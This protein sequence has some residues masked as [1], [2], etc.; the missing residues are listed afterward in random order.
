MTEARQA[1]PRVISSTGELERLLARLDGEGRIALDTEAASFHRYIDRVYLI[2]LG[3]GT[4]T[5]LIDPLSVDDLS[6]LGGL[7]R[8]PRTEIVFHDADYDLRV[9]DRDYGFHARNLFDTQMA[10]RLLGEPAV[11]LGAMLEKHFEVKLNKKLQRADWSRR[12]LSPEML[13]Y[14]ADDVRYLLPLRDLLEQRLRLEGR[15]EWA[16][17]E[18]RQLETVRWTPLAEDQPYL[19]IKGAKALP[20]RALAVLRSLHQWREA[21]ARQHDR[22]PF[23]IM[24]NSSLL[25]IAKARPR[26][27]KQLLGLEGVGV[28]AV[29]VRRYGD[30]LMDAVRDGLTQPESAIARTTRTRRPELDPLYDLRLEQLKVLRNHRA[31]EAGLDPGLLCPNALLQDLARST[32][33]APAELDSISGLRKWQ[34]E[35]L[36]EP[37]ILAALAVER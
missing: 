10:A 13:A 1:P 4:R 35:V 9:L 16:R 36:G 26:S 23:R 34:R 22:A 31:G 25:A 29:L 5:V 33:R 14:A 6:G 24:A 32:P 17:E 18:F 27:L 20:P 3:Y 21:T 15:L 28:P 2:Q 8:D 30:R 7:L 11:G 12:P 19:R 37:E